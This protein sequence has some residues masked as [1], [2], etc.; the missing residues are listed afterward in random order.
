MSDVTNPEQ[1]KSKKSIG[2]WFRGLRPRNKFRVVLLVIVIL[3]APFAIYFGLDEPSQAE[4]GDCMA[5]ASATDLR[6]VECTDAAADWKVLGR[7][8]GKTEADFTDAACAAF[9]ATEVSF[10]E[11]GR[12]FSK[13]YILCLG[14]AG[15]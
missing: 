10:F 2:S 14:P 15:Q 3:V 4:V 7:L 13:G 9:P 11:D 6:T 8:T 5:G 12:R 1:Q